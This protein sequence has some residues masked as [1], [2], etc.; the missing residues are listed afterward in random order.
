MPELPEVALYARDLNFAVHGQNLVACR[1]PNKKN[2][3]NIIIPRPVAQTIKSLIGLRFNF[4]SIGKALYLEAS[5][6]NKSVVEF[7]LGMTGRFFRSPFDN[8]WRAHCFIELHFERCSIYYCDHRRFGRVFRDTEAQGGIGGFSSKRG[9]WF[10]P[11]PIPPTGYK[12]SPRISWLINT[13]HRTGVGNY[14]ANEALGRLNLSPF[15][16]CSSEE[17]AV[18]ILRECQKVARSSFRF[19]GNSFSAGYFRLDG[20]EGRFSG[21]CKFYG[22]PRVPRY[23]FRG[24]PVF[25]FHHPK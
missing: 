22:H 10:D 21:Q 9:L 1:F 25:T 5:Q 12:S 13:G 18:A 3:G 19:G 11:N 6:P 17:E 24:R 4:S 15:Q 23:L 8:R 14:M 7:R 16:P 2:W 20:T